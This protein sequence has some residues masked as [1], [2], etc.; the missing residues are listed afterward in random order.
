MANLRSTLLDE[1]ETKCCP[2]CGNFVARRR[3]GAC[4]YCHT[5]IVP[6][7]VP[8]RGPYAERS[9]KKVRTIYVRDEVQTRPLVE[10]LRGFIRTEI[11]N[12]E[13]DF[14]NWG[15]E[16]GQAGIL[17]AYAKCDM[18][19][20]EGVIEAFFDPEVRTRLRIWQQVRSMAHVV[21]QNGCIN[22][23]LAYAKAKYGFTRA[24]PIAQIGLE[25]EDG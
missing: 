12:P 14:S 19:T 22:V 11:R 20:A 7:N 5:I 13:F 18:Q 10:L 16:C 17:L 24:K 15:A 4:P 25:F 21:S 9:D 3:D 1:I 2:Y 23:A 8:N 6:L